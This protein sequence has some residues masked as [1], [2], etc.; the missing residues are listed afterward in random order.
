VRTLGSDSDAVPGSHGPF[1]YVINVQPRIAS[2]CKGV[3]RY[4]LDLQAE[5]T[6]DKITKY[7]PVTEAGSIHTCSE[8]LRRSVCLNLVATSII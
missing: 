7:L 4:R 2:D 6:I 8:G 3:P 1:D 5:G